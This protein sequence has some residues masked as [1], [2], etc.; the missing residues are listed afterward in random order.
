[1]LMSSSPCS[2]GTPGWSCRP[3][4]HGIKAASWPPGSWP[5]PPSGRALRPAGADPGQRPA[6]I[7]PLHARAVGPVVHANGI[8]CSPRGPLDQHRNRVPRLQRGEHLRASRDTG[9][10][11]PP[12]PDKC[13][14]AGPGQNPGREG[15]DDMRLRGWSVPA[16][17]AGLDQCSG[18]AI[19]PAITGNLT[20]RPGHDLDLELHALLSAVLPGQRL[21]DH[22]G[23]ASTATTTNPY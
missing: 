19:P 7:R 13:R 8:S 2:A 14:L 22:P 23:P 17:P 3:S 12:Q 9:R 18:H 16:T 21:S 10:L 15:Q 5:Q 11:N 1:M 4:R 6:R 20:S